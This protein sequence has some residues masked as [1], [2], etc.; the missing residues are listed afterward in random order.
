MESLGD[1][2]WILPPGSSRCTLLRGPHTH[3]HT[4]DGTTVTSPFQLG[5]SSS[6]PLPGPLVL[7]QCPLCLAAT[8]GPSLPSPSLA[9]PPLPGGVSAGARETQM[10][11]APA[12]L[13]LWAPTSP[14]WAPTSPLWAM[15]SPLWAMTSSDL[16]HVRFRAHSFPG[17]PPREGRGVGTRDLRDD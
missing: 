1:P 14:L 15:T 5:V 17:D 4:V 13:Q 16:Y 12:S 7:A 6:Q 10:M 11:P 9:V 2:D 3:T 8:A